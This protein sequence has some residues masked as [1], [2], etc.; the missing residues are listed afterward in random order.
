MLTFFFFK[1][2]NLHIFTNI[3]MITYNLLLLK[4]INLNTYIFVFFAFCFLQIL[5][6]VQMYVI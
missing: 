6:Y 4:Y 1:W 2:L 3:Y 5:H